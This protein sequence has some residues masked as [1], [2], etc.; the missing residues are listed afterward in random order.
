VFSI[1]AIALICT[2]SALAQ[3]DNS[4]YFVTYYSNNVS[5]APDATVRV[6]NDGSQGSFG[7][8]DLYADIYAFDTSEELITC[9]SCLVTP[10]GLLSESVRGI[11]KDSG[12]GPV[13]AGVIK[14][15][16]G[17][18]GF[19]PQAGQGEPASDVPTSGLRAWAT[20]IQSSANHY[21]AGPAPWYQTETA[22]ADSNLTATEQSLLQMLCWIDILESH[23]AC[24]CTPEDQDF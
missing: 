19:F 14:I 5:G 21:P 6:I 15:I 8:G 16:S 23:P 22:F 17:K 12:E 7:A 9:C 18:N 1:V 3:G 24:S 13:D 2:G 10:D 20:H 4:V 11:V